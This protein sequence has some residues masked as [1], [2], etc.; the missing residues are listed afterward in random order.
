[1]TTVDNAN[2]RQ[3]GGTVLS[4]LPRDRPP[5]LQELHETARMVAE[6]YRLRGQIDVE[7]EQLALNLEH[8]VDVW[9]GNVE[10]LEDTSDH[11]AWL[12]AK[13]GAIAW[14]FWDRYRSWLEL[15]RQFSPVVVGRLESSIDEVLARLEDPN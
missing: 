2:Y 15:E 13:R 14:N 9:D 4:L 12:P 3:A 1:M 5:T 8:H 10:V 11:V 7:A 6:M